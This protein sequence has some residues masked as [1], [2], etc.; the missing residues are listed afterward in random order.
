MTALRPRLRPRDRKTTRPSFPNRFVLLRS[1]T[2]PNIVDS[3]APCHGR[4]ARS[5]L[6]RAAVN[7]WLEPATRAE[8][9]LLPVADAHRGEEQAINFFLKSLI[10]AFF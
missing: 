10:P 5:I 8:V 3:D 6:D 7:F 4:R 9:Q 1:G 2:I